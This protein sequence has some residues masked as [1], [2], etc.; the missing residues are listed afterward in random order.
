[1]CNAAAACVPST[2]RCPSLLQ[3]REVRQVGASVVV[4]FLRQKPRVRMLNRA[5]EGGGRRGVRRRQATPT[6][7]VP[8]RPAPA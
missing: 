6:Q 5:G 4:S 3:V 1:M 7:A 2:L 8:A